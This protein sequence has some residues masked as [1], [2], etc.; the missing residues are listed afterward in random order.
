MRELITNLESIQQLAEQRYDDFE[1]LR[2]MLEIN[3]DISD[4]QID[5]IVEAVAQPIV[6]AIDCKLC[7]NCC[8]SLDVY[9]TKQDAQTLADG[10]HV[11]LDNIMT[12]VDQ[13]SAQKVKEWGKFKA[14]PCGF[15]KGNLCSVYA[16]RPE[17]CRTYPMFTPDFR[18]T[19]DNMIDGASICPI[20]YNVLVTLVDEVHRFYQ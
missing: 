19:L 20:I 5:A 17:T 14:R 18:W 13:E 2:Y 9:L 6:D 1:V 3:E 7:G 16:H 12:L 10:I 8:R 4:S 15:L 11:S